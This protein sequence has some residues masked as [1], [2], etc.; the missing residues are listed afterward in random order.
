M[1]L[2]VIQRQLE[3]IY[4]VE[5]PHDVD[6][7][8]I[9]DA[10]MARNLGQIT[11]VPTASEQLFVYEEADSLDV[12]LYIDQSVVERLDNDDPT[13]HLHDGNIADF[14]TVLEGVSH[15]LYLIWNARFGR[16]VSAIELELQA[17]VDKYI[18]SSFL[19]GKQGSGHI[20]TNLANILFNEPV[21]DSRLDCERL[22]RYQEANFYAEEFCRVLEN[23]YL[24]MRRGDGLVNEIRRFYRL[25]R[26]KKVEHI[27]AASTVRNLK[28][29]RQ[30]AQAPLLS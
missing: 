28:F 4:Q 7:F 20:P 27:A 18:A 1:Q 19:F 26:W 8:V 13:L 24:K 10:Q 25:T 14:C 3:Q 23:R 6:D 16:E 2:N 5:I 12:S 29:S 22:K 15:F 9:S 21:F 11:G 30:H 17:E